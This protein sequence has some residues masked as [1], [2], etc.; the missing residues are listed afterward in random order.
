MKI[1]IIGKF[2][3]IEGGVSVR[4]YWAARGLAERGHEVFVVT[5]AD[6]V[7][8]A[9]RVRLDDADDAPQLAPEFPETGGFVKVFSPERFGP[10]MRHSPTANPFVSKL[11]GLATQVLTD[12]GC[13]VIVAN[14]FEPYAVAGHLAATWTDVPLLVQH[15]GT[16]VDRLMRIPE[17]ATTYKRVLRAADGVI[18]TPR[19]V[20]RFAGMGVRPAAIHLLSTYP[21]PPAFTPDAEP[22]HPADVGRL[23]VRPP[24]A[25]VPPRAFDPR[26]PTIGMYGKP[27]EVK[28]T[29]DLI[30][31]LGM[32]RGEGL[33]F[34]LLL[35]IGTGRAADV[36]R[37]VMDG[38]LADSAWVLPFLPH[39]RVPRFIRT[40]TAVCFL[41]RDFPIAI[42][43]PMVPREV[44]ACGTCLVLSGEILG[45]QHYRDRLGDGDNFVVA[46]DPKDRAA[47]ADRLRPLITHPERARAIGARGHL[48]AAGFPDYADVVDAWEALLTPF[49]DRAPGPDAGPEAGPE[50]GSDAGPA[51]T[52]AQ[53]DDGAGQTTPAR[54]A[55]RITGELPWLRAALR[56]PD[57]LLARFVEQRAAG[58]GLTDLGFTD[59]GFTD[60][61]LTD[62]DLADEFCAYLYERIDDRAVRPGL[63]RECLRDIVRYQWARHWAARDER[64]GDRYATPPP[65]TNVLGGRRPALENIRELCPVVGV[66][67]RVEHFDHD[68]TPLFCDVDT[69]HT[70]PGHTNTGHTDTGRDDIGTDRA[71]ALPVLPTLPR[72]ATT[73]CFARMP[74]LAPCERRVN[75]ATER[76]LALCDGR[77]T[78]KEIAL[79]L[80]REAGAPLP[81]ERLEQDVQDACAL[82]RELYSSGIVVFRKP[83]V[84]GAS[85][86]EQPAEALGR[87]R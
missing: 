34:N 31:A 42:H 87:S 2:P 39:W 11:A 62:L 60:L 48:V 80:A 32:L 16:D 53:T 59:L 22:L 83:A 20:G 6:E 47:L 84:P 86:L 68:V 71:A 9:F 5:N 51:A 38:G 25:P 26:L 58:P 43:G 79:R 55:D 21:Y 74:N 46:P 13:E 78:T 4:T 56:S 65:V 12:A 49:A 54:M 7:E 50:A 17:L 52:D 24:A 77:A 37:A 85:T 73:V 35:M 28:G 23:A 41:E 8:D 18:T 14:Y 57:A 76:L 27:G 36:G 3:P 1:C 10:R 66:P 15:A 19:L 40:C 72:A 67:V 75:A 64:T 30:G 70:D 45:K 63:T 82:L 61:D 69:G 33:R 44:L 81:A 29:Y